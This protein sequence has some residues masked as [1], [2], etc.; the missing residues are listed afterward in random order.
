MGRVNIAMGKFEES[1]TEFS[2]SIFYLSRFQGAEA[3][4]TSMGYYRLGDVFLAQG[5]VENALAFFDKVVDIW[6][7][8]LSALYDPEA[9]AR[10]LENDSLSLSQ[11][12]TQQGSLTFVLPSNLESLSEEQLA[13]GSHQ[14]NQVS[15]CL[16]QGLA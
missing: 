1:K 13:D 4:S 7:K 3:V 9:D 5:F 14:L 2:K 10:A 8:Y 15:L 11:T 16:S 12:Q 6:F